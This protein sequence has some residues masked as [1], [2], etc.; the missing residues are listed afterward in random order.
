[1][2]GGVVGVQEEHN[3]NSKKN[4]ERI[5]H[6]QEPVRSPFKT[7]AVV[8]ADINTVLKQLYG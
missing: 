4:P 6:V 3:L 2:C 8:P 7:Q 1:V 5:D